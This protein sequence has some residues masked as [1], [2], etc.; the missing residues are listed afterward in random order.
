MANKPGGAAIKDIDDALAAM[1]KLHDRLVIHFGVPGEA[2]NASRIVG[3]TLVFWEKEDMDVAM[4]CFV[5]TKLA[6]SLAD[7]MRRALL[8]CAETRT[9][10]R[11]MAPFDP[12]YAEKNSKVKTY[13]DE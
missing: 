6:L 5:S 8:V 12:T 4:M 10:A 9:A 11:I 1:Q 7:C 3:E 2:S 13:E